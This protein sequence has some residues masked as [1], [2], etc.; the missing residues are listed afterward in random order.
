MPRAGD[1]EWAAVATAAMRRNEDD[2]ARHARADRATKT[3]RCRRFDRPAAMTPETQSSAA[4]WVG[5]RASARRA[6]RR[7]REM[8]IDA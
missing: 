8:R 2:H 6:C 4:E 3:W 1:S 7:T 5:R